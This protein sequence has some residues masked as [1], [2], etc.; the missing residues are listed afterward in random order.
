MMGLERCRFEP[1]YRQIPVQD[2]QHFTALR[3]FL[4]AGVSPAPLNL[5]LILLL[6]GTGTRFTGTHIAP[7]SLLGDAGNSAAFSKAF[8]KTP[9]TFRS[10]RPT[11]SFAPP[12]STRTS[13]KTETG[14]N[15]RAPISSSPALRPRSIRSKAP[16]QRTQVALNGEAKKEPALPSCLIATFD[17]SEKRSSR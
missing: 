5:L 17:H 8:S 11:P 9:S 10:K 3:L 15:P 7:A 2:E 12:A 4:N 14:S 1:C 13:T 16:C 6:G